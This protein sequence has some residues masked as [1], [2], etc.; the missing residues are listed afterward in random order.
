MGH[1]GKSYKAKTTQILML[2][3]I[4][5]EKQIKKEKGKP[6]KILNYNL[7]T[8]TKEGRKVTIT[9]DE[10]KQTINHFQ[11]ILKEFETWHTQEQ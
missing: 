9:V 11:N 7:L 6:D 8:K 2:N 10:L 4:S 1:E 3:I 5:I